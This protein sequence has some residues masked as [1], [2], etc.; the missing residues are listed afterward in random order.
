MLAKVDRMSMLNSL[1][2][3]TPLLSKNIVEFAW[4]LPD[5]YKLQGKN[6]KR[7]MKD[8][9]R[10][11]LPQDF[12]RLPKSGFGIPLDDWFRND[13]KPFVHEYLSRERIEKQGIFDYGYIEKML[14]DHENG[15]V[16]YKSQIWALLVFEKWLERYP[17]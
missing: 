4:S 12:D 5:E 11:I 13:L 14:R 15:K 3:R 7:I 1:E 16:N 2:T 9:F 6:K 10:D 17:G 8:A